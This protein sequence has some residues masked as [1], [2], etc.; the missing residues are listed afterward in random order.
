MRSKNG[1]IID[2]KHREEIEAAIAKANGKAYERTLTTDEVFESVGHILERTHLPIRKLAGS[3]FTVDLHSSKPSWKNYPNLRTTQA[4]IY[5]ANG[6]AYLKDVFR[7]FGHWSD[8]IRYFGV[9]SEEAKQTL[10][11]INSEFK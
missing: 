1:I 8:D 6:K 2:E 3:T 7:K 10:M 4:V 9:L 5:F 11:R